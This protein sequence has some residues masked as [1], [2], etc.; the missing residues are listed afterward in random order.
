MN[1]YRTS[2]PGLLALI[3]LLAACGPSGEADPCQQSDGACTPQLENKDLEPELDPKPDPE[4]EP[5]VEPEPKIDPEP[6]AKPEPETKPDPDAPEYYV[7]DERGLP[8]PTHEGS[9]RLVDHS[10]SQFCAVDEFS[11]LFCV[12][13]DF[14]TGLGGALAS[15]SIRWPKASRRSP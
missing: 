2:L 12:P 4:I 5:E 10:S 11:R 13:F 7:L 14:D 15:A 8:T 1:A 3:A 6:E 9:F